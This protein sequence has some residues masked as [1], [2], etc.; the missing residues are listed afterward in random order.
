[1]QSVE[2]QGEAMS[3][4]SDVIGLYGAADRRRSDA[5]LK[6]VIKAP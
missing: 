6:W 3:P 1:M 5:P 2:S 4:L